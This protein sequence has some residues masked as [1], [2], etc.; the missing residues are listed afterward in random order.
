ML[1]FKN[2]KVKIGEKELLKE[3]NLSIEK[4]K[5]TAI[6]GES[7]SG[8][9]LLT[10][11]I[12]K[13]IP[14]YIEVCGEA[15]FNGE[16]LL[17]KREGELQKIRGYRVSY[18]F[19]EPMQSLNPLHR[20]GKQIGEIITTHNLI[21][22]KE[23]KDRVD[24]LLQKVKLP[25]Y[26]RDRYP[27]EL[28]GGERQRILIA[29]AIA[30]SP[31]LLI[32]DE[33]ITALDSEVADEVLK[34]LK[35][36]DTTIIFISHNLPIVK[37]FADYIAV[38]KSGEVIERGRVKEI[39]NSPKE[40]Y[41]E[42]LL[43]P[44]ISKPLKKVTSK[45]IALKVENLSINYN[46]IDRVKNISFDLMDGESIALIGRSGSGKSS[47]AK[48]IVKLVNSRG[49]IKSFGEQIQIVFQDPFGSLSPRITI[50]ET[51]IEGLKLKDRKKDYSSKLKEIM[52]RVQLPYE[53]KD[54]YPHELSGGQRQRVSIA[55]ALI[56]KPKIVILDEP[57]SALDRTVQIEVVKLLRELQE[58]M[59][60]S[61]LFITHDL[62]VAKPLTHRFI[63]IRDGE[64]IKINEW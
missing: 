45:N 12:T 2:L 8:K 52:D 28:S 51:I 38:M 24:N 13:L 18:I 10:T 20:V 15:I 25:I 26:Y 29:M 33:P 40:S 49:T 54:R 35:S 61:Y 19:Q 31:D 21:S 5:I 39:F 1:E 58:D 57:T 43:Q 37:D 14:N 64:I 50:G 53:L 47:I 32:A 59:G 22:R 56:L 36:L 7:G 34:L 48:A 44:F 63:E 42:K 41:T 30:N 55:R 11:A 46:G 16:D 62:E 27:H 9:T 4:G 60:I 3:V 17:Q 23:L 6:V